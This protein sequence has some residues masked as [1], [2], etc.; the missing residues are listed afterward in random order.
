V[1]P[2][3][4][5]PDLSGERPVSSPGTSLHQLILA[6]DP[7]AIAGFRDS[8]VHRIRRY[9]AEACPAE[10]RD[11]AAEAT[12]VNFL[13]RVATA[14]DGDLEE[15][16][17]RSTRSCAA[18]RFDVQA[19][20]G[21]HRHAGGPEPV[22]LAMPE[23]LAAFANDELPGQHD[24]AQHHLDHCPTCA[25]TAERMARA[26]QAF[27]EAPAWE[28]A[29]EQWLAVVETPD[30]AR[31]PAPPDRRRGPVLPEGWGPIASSSRSAP[32]PEPEPDPDPE[33]AAA[34]APP[35]PAPEPAP[36]PELAP[37]P[38]SAPEPEPEPKPEPEPE[39][40]P[41]PEPEAAP[42]PPPAPKPAPPPQPSPPPATVVR[43]RQGGLVGAARRALR[44]R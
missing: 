23:L 37:E 6:G 35:E 44:D 39:P 12:F 26:E 3:V 22:C 33:P 34:T 9:V 17:L 43:R 42:A 14:Q 1:V 7:D 21:A 28:A 27:T 20:A 15:L 36:E 16:L 25:A 18:G 5:H 19:A 31:G 10:L 32:S 41:V 24:A 4:G 2:P 29:P 13:G 38:V 30:R 11:E 40:E 8:H